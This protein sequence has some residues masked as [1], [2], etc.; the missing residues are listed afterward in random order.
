MD[1]NECVRVC[2]R[3]KITDHAWIRIEFKNYNDRNKYREF[4][5]RDYT[6]INVDKF[7]SEL[8]KNTIRKEIFEIHTKADGFIDNIVSALDIVAPKKIF[9]IPKVW[10]G[11]GWFSEE[12][13]EASMS[14]DNAYKKAVH[15]GIK[16]DWIQFKL[17]RN[18]VVKLIKNKKREYYEDKID[19]NRKDP[20]KM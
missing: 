20:Q 8:E 7:V 9:K 3:P 15:T 2:E 5:G 17:K 1:M 6:K 16:W 18:A 10:E 13:R 11:K 19:S 14:R 12:I 4:V